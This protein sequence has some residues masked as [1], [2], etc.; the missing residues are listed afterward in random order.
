MVMDLARPRQEQHHA[1]LGC[2]AIRDHCQR[3]PVPVDGLDL[4]V[5][6]DKRL[7][8]RTLEKM[9]K[10]TPHRQ[11]SAVG[12][13]PPTKVREGREGVGRVNITT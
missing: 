9:E 11:L 10:R 6:C 7:D 13:P 8:A 2:V 12:R 1:A 3:N 4:R 5:I